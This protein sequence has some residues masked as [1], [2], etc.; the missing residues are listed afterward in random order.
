MR[1]AS[2][3]SLEDVDVWF[4]TYN[5][6]IHTIFQTKYYSVLWLNDRNGFSSYIYHLLHKDPV[7][8]L[9]HFI[10]YR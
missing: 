9:R 2:K 7:S 5:F 10:A 6:L 8:I 1:E 4:A 3:A